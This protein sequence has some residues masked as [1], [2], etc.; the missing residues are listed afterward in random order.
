[1]DNFVCNAFTF[2]VKITFLLWFFLI[3]FF[4]K[5][6]LSMKSKSW[7]VVSGLVQTG[8][9]CSPEAPGMWTVAMNGGA[10]G[11]G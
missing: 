10:H 7:H 6:F 2:K 8:I 4:T 9:P 5:A 11:Q 3:H 1:M